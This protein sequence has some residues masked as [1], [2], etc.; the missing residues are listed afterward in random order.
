MPPREAASPAWASS[1]VAPRA[2]QPRNSVG[3]DL[4]SAGGSRLTY[5]DLLRAARSAAVRRCTPST[6]AVRLL[7]RSRSP[8]DVIET[9]CALAPSSA[10]LLGQ[11]PDDEA[12]AL[13]IDR[14]RVLGL[15]SEKAE[16]IGRRRG[17]IRSRAG[18]RHLV[19]QCIFLDQPAAMIERQRIAMWPKRSRLVRCPTAARNNGRGRPFRA[20]VP[21]FCGLVDRRRIRAEIVEPRS[22]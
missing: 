7:Q 11:C 21:C 15:L 19:E 3:R 14:L 9:E 4:G 22:A 16:R 6:Q 8:S 10:S 2:L 20:C 17:R 5:A 13:R 18:H 1:R 12:R